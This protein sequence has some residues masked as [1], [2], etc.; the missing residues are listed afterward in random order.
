MVNSYVPITNK[1]RSLFRG[2]DLIG[3]QDLNAKIIKP[4]LNIPLDNS[5]SISLLIVHR[6]ALKRK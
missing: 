2:A 1:G 5:V 4:L 3:F 6:E